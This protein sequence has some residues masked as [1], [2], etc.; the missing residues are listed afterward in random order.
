MWN[1]PADLRYTD[2]HEWVRTEADGTLTIGLT[3]PAQNTLEDIGFL[4]LPPVGKQVT[5][6]EAVGVL[7]S[8]KVSYENCS[9]VTGEVIAA[10]A[11]A[12]DTPGELNA[13]AYRT[14]LYRIR[15]AV[16]AC[17]DCLL[18]AAEYARKVG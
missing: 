18:T 11:D 1:V 17:T 10:N 8:V 3:D 13:D 6:G 12:V 4:Q 15:L 7:E 2:A 9:P 14:W 5:A 16:G